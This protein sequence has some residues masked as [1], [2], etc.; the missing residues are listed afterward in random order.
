MEATII[1]PVWNDEE[2]AVEC[3]ESIK[4]QTLKDFECIIVDDGSTDNTLD[5]VSKC[6]SGDSRFKVIH[7]EHN[8]LSNARNI[9]IENASTEI[10]FHIDS[11][12]HAKPEM[13]EHVVKF[14]NENELDMAF[15]DAEVQRANQSGRRFTLDNRYFKRKKSYGIASGAEMLN[16]MVDADDYVYAVFIQA[17]RKSA[18]KRKFQYGLRAQDLLYSTQNMILQNRLGHLPE[19][20]YV[21][22]C[23][24]DS[25]SEGR[26]D[27]HYAW[28]IFRTIMEMLKFMDEEDVGKGTYA[29]ENIMQDL[30]NN[31]SSIVKHLSNE[32]WEYI[33][34]KPFSD[35]NLMKHIARFAMLY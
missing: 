23:R 13:M 7:A 11:D 21:K 4:S 14:L 16:A 26:K 3:I 10:I 32:D 1:L 17:I 28:S 25:V 35:S 27:G 9:G 22:M 12:D 2:R 24:D 15:Y 19:I 31:Y 18:I 30:F 34:T 33:K 5:I 29:V 6:V 8:G 20:L